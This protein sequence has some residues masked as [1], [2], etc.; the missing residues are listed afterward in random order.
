MGW[1]VIKITSNKM[2]ALQYGVLDLRKHDDH[3]LK[4]Q[5]IFKQISEIVNE[6][7]PD[8]MALEAPFFGKNVQSM[9]KLGRAQGV[10]MAAALAVEVPITE[11]APLKVK[12]SIT[13][14]G[15]ASK[16]QVADMVMKLLNL[17]ELPKFLDATDALA[18]AITHHFQGGNQTK[19]PS[20]WN[21]FLSQNPNRIK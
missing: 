7:N 2:K 4:L 3:Y 9:L 10:A 8:E 18:V 1:A 20:N 16:E 12:K 17:K 14:K 19:R 21:S 5:K 11:Y 13:G 15:Q 6:F